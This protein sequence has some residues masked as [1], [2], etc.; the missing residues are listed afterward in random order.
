MLALHPSLQLL[1]LPRGAL[2]VA[3]GVGLEALSPDRL[4]PVAVWRKGH[5]VREAPLGPSEA[6]ALRRALA[7]G[8]VASVCEAF[9]DAPNPGEAAIAALVEWVGDDWIC[10][11]GA[12]AR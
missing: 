8:D 1:S 12:P 9:A 4:Q 5:D 6:E 10:G 11:A 2:E 7:G 3:G